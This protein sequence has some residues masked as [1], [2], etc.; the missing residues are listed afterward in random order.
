M[1][2]DKKKNKMPPLDA[3][4]RIRFAEAESYEVFGG[5][6]GC[7]ELLLGCRD[8]RYCFDHVAR[9]Y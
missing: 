3:A 5:I 8:S 1:H 4:W 2:T 7:V 9:G 6:R